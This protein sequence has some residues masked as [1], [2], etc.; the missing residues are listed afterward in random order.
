MVWEGGIE[1]EISKKKKF[2]SVRKIQSPVT[3]GE[4]SRVSGKVLPPQTQAV[5]TAPVSDGVRITKRE[6]AAGLSP[7]SKLK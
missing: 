3:R 7:E 5:T 6:S 4:R 1:N 2:T